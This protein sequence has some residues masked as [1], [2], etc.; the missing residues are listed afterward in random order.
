MQGWADY[1]RVAT[2]RSCKR[3]PVEAGARVKKKSAFFASA[4]VR[5]CKRHTD[6]AAEVAEGGRRIFCPHSDRVR[7]TPH[8]T[9]RPPAACPGRLHLRLSRADFLNI[10]SAPQVRLQI[11]AARLESLMHV[12]STL[13][14]WSGAHLNQVQ[15]SMRTSEPRWRHCHCCQELWCESRPSK[16]RLAEIWTNK[17]GLW[18]AATAA[19]KAKRSRAINS[20]A[21]LALER[22]REFKNTPDPIHGLSR[23]MKWKAPVPKSAPRRQSCL[24]HR[25]SRL[26]KP[27]CDY[28]QLSNGRD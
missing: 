23:S 28:L 6:S 13:Q 2:R 22:A 11:A 3:R 5:P 15:H 7:H 16:T 19:A 26:P 21:F 20:P 4:T 18:D 1:S 14:L 25:S 8:A 17:R 24:P 10:P 12:T 9:A 27:C